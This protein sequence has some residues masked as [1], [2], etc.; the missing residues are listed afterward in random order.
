VYVTA[1]ALSNAFYFGDPGLIFTQKHVELA[2][3][4][5]APLIGGTRSLDEARAF[6]EFHILSILDRRVDVTGVELHC[7]ID[8]AVLWGIPYYDDGLTLVDGILGLKMPSAALDEIDA[9]RTWWER[10]S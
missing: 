1:F 6:V 4:D 2:A 5:P 10:R 8:D 7:V 3:A 9:L